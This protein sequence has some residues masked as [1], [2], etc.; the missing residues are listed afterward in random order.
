[1]QKM[2]D[3]RII[4]EKKCFFLYGNRDKYK[5]FLLVNISIEMEHLKVMNE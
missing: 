1:M 3:S 5:H 4:I 2:C